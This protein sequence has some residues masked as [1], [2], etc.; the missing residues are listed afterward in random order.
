MPDQPQLDSL[1]EACCLPP[2]SEAEAKIPLAMLKKLLASVVKTKPELLLASSTGGDSYFAEFLYLPF[3]N[4]ALDYA[5]AVHIAHEGIKLLI[6]AYHEAIESGVITKKQYADILTRLT[7][8][9]SLMHEVLK[10]GSL[11]IY[12]SMLTELKTLRREGTISPAIY[13]R[14]F[15]SKKANWFTPLHEL[16]KYGNPELYEKV[17]AELRQLHRDMAF[18]LVSPDIPNDKTYADQFLRVTGHGYTLMHD[19]IAAGNVTLYQRAVADL[20][21]LRAAGIITEQQYNEQFTLPTDHGVTPLHVAVSSGNAALLDQVLND[22]GKALS[23]EEMQH[24][25]LYH[26]D[27]KSN[28]FHRAAKISEAKEAPDS[29]LINRLVGAFFD[30]FDAKEAKQHIDVL[31]NEK[32]EHGLTPYHPSRPAW[33]KQ[34]LTAQTERPYHPPPPRKR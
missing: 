17:T 22:M 20:H 2:A 28:V 30:Y 21:E 19:I 7:G 14:Q 4:E 26:T 18:S 15:I 3:Q 9:E 33:L 34:L 16:V 10:T 8:N 31:V 24:E 25:L 29:F 12:N 23:R 6:A 1:V 27:R 5:A 11:E 13:A 32:N